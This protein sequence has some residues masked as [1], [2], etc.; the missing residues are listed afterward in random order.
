MGA[1]LPFSS[2][3]AAS[4]DMALSQNR[5]SVRLPEALSPLASAIRR[6]ASRVSR[7]GGLARERGMGSIL[8]QGLPFYRGHACNA[9][10]LL[11]AKGLGLVAKRGVS[12]FRH[13]RLLGGGIASRGM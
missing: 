11:A 3:F 4:A 7:G 8:Q 2:S 10:Q 5:S 1:S 6:S 12:G 9:A 13:L